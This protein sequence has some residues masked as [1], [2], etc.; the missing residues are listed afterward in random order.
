M[1]PRLDTAT[2]ELLITLPEHQSADHGD[3][4]LQQALALAAEGW[5]VFPIRPGTKVP[6]FPNPHK[7]EERKS[8]CRGEC[9]QIGHGAWDGTTDA[10]TIRKWWGQH[11]NAGIGAN[12]GDDRIAFDVDLNHGGRYL[13][14]FPHTRKHLS[15]RGNGNGHLIYKYDPATAA[16]AIQ[17]GNGALGDGMDIKTGRGSY[18]IMPGTRHEDTG[19]LYTVAPDNAGIEHV[20]LDSEV[21]AIFAEAGLPSPSVRRHKTGSKQEASRGTATPRGSLLSELLSNPPAEGGRNDWLAKV[22]GHKASRHR[23]EPDLFE[24]ELRVANGLLTEPLD[25]AE[26]QKTIWSVWDIEQSKPQLLTEDAREKAIEEA[27]DRLRIAAAARRRVA[28]EQ[29]LDA[30]NPGRMV[31]G[32]EFTLDIPDG[33]PAVWGDGGQVLWAE[34]EALM[35]VGPPGVGKTTLSNQLVRSRI[36]LGGDVLGLPVVP[37]KRRV[38]YLAMDRP[39]QIARSLRRS[40]RPHERQMLDERLV[41]WQGPPPADLA[42]HPETLLD[43]AKQASADTV[44]IDSL[45][46]AAIGLTEDEVGAGYN[47]ARQLALAAGV[48]VL[49]I[50]HMVKNG[51]NGTKPNNLQSVYGSAW[52]TAGAGSVILLWGEAGDTTVELVHLKQPA[53]TL[54]P[55]QLHHDH[56]A[57]VTTVLQGTTTIDLLLSAGD[58]GLSAADLASLRDDDSR[59]GKE[60][61][62]RDLQRLVRQE[63]ATEAVGE[64]AG[65]SVAI[66]RATPETRG[67]VF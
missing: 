21:D 12:L 17:S 55:W 64:R 52:L 32:G 56:Q 27:A 51:A 11:P 4:N 40:F 44:I 29:R 36:G 14:S 22:A 30:D 2:R 28:D 62:R 1:S 54:G 15:G 60:K 20:L 41:V 46:D 31:D 38:L 13:E 3:S 45:K 57:G 24:V 47:R 7:N 65:Q 23:S 6:L 25:E 43:M 37:S 18:I 10:D 5:H 66:F 9:G 19:K 48:E 63:L 49:E 26:F 39:R 35:V 34:G 16:A 59:A 42:A 58:R 67:Q 8:R 61:A 50:H 33:T 53:E